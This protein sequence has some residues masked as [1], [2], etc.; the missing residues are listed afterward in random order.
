MSTHG[1]RLHCGDR[2]SAIG[3]LRERLSLPIAAG[4]LLLLGGLVVVSVPRPRASSRPQP[5]AC[6]PPAGMEPN[7]RPVKA[8][9]ARQRTEERLHIPG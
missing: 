4:T 2:R 7:E 5:A 1:V 9:S 6:F 3:I 8:D